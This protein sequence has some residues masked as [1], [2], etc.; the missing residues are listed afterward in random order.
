M[1]P[2]QRLKSLRMV[3]DGGKRKLGVGLSGEKGSLYLGDLGVWFIS[4]DI[5]FAAET[6]CFK[7]F[8][9]VIFHAF[10]AGE[11]RGD[12]SGVREVEFR[13]PEFVIHAVDTFIVDEG[14]I[15]LD[16]NFGVVIEEAP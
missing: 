1:E 14:L 4:E 8:D 12:D 13:G 7:E 15:F 16:V 9:D 10:L 6:F 11:F 3:R 2:A 5:E